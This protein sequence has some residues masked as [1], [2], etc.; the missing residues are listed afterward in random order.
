MTVPQ[1]LNIYGDLTA[2]FDSKEQVP[3]A[4]NKKE[5]YIFKKW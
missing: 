2:L 4:S 1:Y 3:Y 5:K